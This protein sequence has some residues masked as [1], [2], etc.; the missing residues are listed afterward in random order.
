[1]QTRLTSNDIQRVAEEMLGTTTWP[2]ATSNTHRNATTDQRLNHRAD[3][4]L[5][6]LNNLLRI[7]RDQF[8]AHQSQLRR[9]VTIIL[10]LQLVSKLPVLHSAKLR[11]N[12]A[13][14]S[15]Q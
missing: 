12:I 5:A 8:R 11:N 3:T 4:F 10:V 2:R 13:A 14:A 6:T 9:I 1:M 15:R 7:L